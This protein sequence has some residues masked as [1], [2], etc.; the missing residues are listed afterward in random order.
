MKNLK[1]IF[2]FLVIALAFV[3]AFKGATIVPSILVMNGFIEA[4]AA[5]FFSVAIFLGIVVLALDTAVKKLRGQSAFAYDTIDVTSLAA[6][7]VK[8][9]GEV[10][11]KKVNAWDPGQDFMMAKNVKKPIPLP[12]LSSIGEPR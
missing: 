6:S 4:T 12:K 9:G 8:F 11:L 10:I 3:A 7:I 2:G 1:N 5:D